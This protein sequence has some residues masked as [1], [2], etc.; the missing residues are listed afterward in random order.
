MPSPWKEFSDAY[1]KNTPENFYNKVGGDIVR[2]KTDQERLGLL[3]PERVQS[4]KW[5]W[6]HPSTEPLS[7]S[8]ARFAKSLGSRHP[9]FDAILILEQLHRLSKAQGY[10]FNADEPVG[11]RLQVENGNIHLFESSQERVQGPLIVLQELTQA[12]TEARTQTTET[13]HKEQTELGVEMRKGQLPGL[14]SQ[15]FTDTENMKFSPAIREIRNYFGA[16][17]PS[18]EEFYE[19]LMIHYSAGDTGQPTFSDYI[20]GFLSLLGELEASPESYDQ[21][22]SVDRLD[23]ENV[24]Y[25]QDAL[26]KIQDRFCQDR[27]KYYRPD[28]DALVAQ[29]HPEIE[30]QARD[31]YKN[32]G[33]DARQIHQ[34]PAVFLEFALR[35]EQVRREW[36]DDVQ[37][38]LSMTP[39]NGD[40]DSIGPF[41]VNPATYWRVLLMEKGITPAPSGPYEAHGNRLLALSHGLTTHT[42]TAKTLMDPNKALAAYQS[43]LR[44]YIPPRGQAI[45]VALDKKDGRG[46][47][48]YEIPLAA[49]YSFKDKKGERVVFTHEE[50]RLAEAVARYQGTSLRFLSKDTEVPTE[51][52]LI[53]QTE[54]TILNNEVTLVLGVA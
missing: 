54:N 14:L 23:V 25:V 18:S 53:S 8:L 46:I 9:T 31:F 29:I 41:Q 30:E 37:D 35:R 42:E 26:E 47:Q 51:G 15:V 40:E 1:R 48:D 11:V 20:D 52:N 44:M 21:E 33:L 2:A 36:T 13:A 28:I 22:E 39:L 38:A 6:S 50:M 49:S 10:A 4:A 45:T 32:M 3:T 34:P 24:Q 7:A 16:Q 12:H 17:K 19:A 5:E 27:Q 43:I